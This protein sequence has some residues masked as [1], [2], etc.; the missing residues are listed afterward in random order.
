VEAIMAELAFKAHHYFADS[1]ARKIRPLAT[2]I[3]G[4]SADEAL[5]LL[6]FLPNKGA[7][8]LEAVVKS[9]IGNA[10]YQREEKGLD[11]DVDDLIV[12]ESRIDGGPIMKRI[13]PRARG[14]AYPIKKRIAHIHVTVAPPQADE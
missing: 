5:Q 2:L 6:R 1:S 10:E 8:L 13:Q 3:R 4:R 7:R 12:T 9:A 11:F 14:T